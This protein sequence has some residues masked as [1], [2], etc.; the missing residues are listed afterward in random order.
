MDRAKNREVV[1]QIAK[2]LGFDLTGFAKIEPLEKETELLKEWISRGY[3]GTMAYLERNLERRHDPREI[4]PAAVSV[5]SLGL[6]YWQPGGFSEGKGKVSKYAWGRDYHFTIWEKLD[7]FKLRLSEIFPDSEST[8]YVDTGPVMDKMWAVRAGLGWQGKHSNVINR[9]IGS[10]FFIANIFTSIP[11]TYDTPITDHCGSCTACIDACPT[12]AITQPYVV[13]G[14]SCISFLTIE[15]KGE[16]DDKFEGKMENWVFGCDICQEVCPW[17]IKFETPTEI[18]DFTVGYTPKFA[19][20]GGVAPGNK[21]EGN[22]ISESNPKVINREFDLHY[23]DEVENGRF[24]REFSESPILRA[25][26]KGMLRNCE[27]VRRES[28]D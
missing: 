11:F 26:L 12:G 9:G 28:A 1:L 18:E 5:I 3:A 14:S 27:F 21:T 23:F 7:K 25:K 20:I 16:I 17:N 24:K 2:E 4:L 15:N 10:W 8:S 19:D 6:N 22:S 13:D